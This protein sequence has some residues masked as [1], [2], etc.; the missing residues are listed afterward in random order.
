MFESRENLLDEIILYA[1]ANEITYNN[2]LKPAIEDYGDTADEA[3]WEVA[4]KAVI[5]DYIRDT[6]PVGLAQAWAITANL[7]TQED[8]KYIASAFMDYYEE[9]IEEARAES[10]KK[11]KA[12]MKELFGE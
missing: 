11:H 4:A 9:E 10:I 3:E 6:L 2:V 8:V 5:D 7:F 12:K 1:N